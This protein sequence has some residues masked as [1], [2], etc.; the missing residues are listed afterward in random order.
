MSGAAGH[1]RSSTYH[2]LSWTSKMKINHLEREWKTDKMG[3]AWSS[4]NQRGKRARWPWTSPCTSPRAKGWSP[5]RGPTKM[6]VEWQKYGKGKDWEWSSREILLWERFSL[7]GLVMTERRHSIGTRR[8][9]R[10]GESARSLT[11]VGCPQHLYEHG[12][13]V[14]KLP[15]RNGVESRADGK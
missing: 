14:E 4:M 10:R 12:I 3:S 9:R 13:H 8:K 11:W 7:C 15:Q 2:L 1:W 6:T 5:K